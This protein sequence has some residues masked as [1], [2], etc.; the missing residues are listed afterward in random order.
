MTRIVG[1]VLAAL[2]AGC[3]TAAPPPAGRSP[4]SGSPQ[5]FATFDEGGVT[6]LYPAGWRVFHHLATSSFSSS[7]ADLATIDVPDPCV[8]TSD[9]VG[10]STECGDR[11]HLEPNTLVVHLEP[12]T[13]VV[14]L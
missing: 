11:F 9:A 12:N 5:G 2:L 1:L 7:I 13:L 3:G 14:H 8:T 6:F 4:G 10:T